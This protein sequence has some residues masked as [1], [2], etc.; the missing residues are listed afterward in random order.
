M[1]T[2]DAPQNPERI[3]VFTD[4]P[5]LRQGDPSLI[6]ECNLLRMKILG[7]PQNLTRL[8]KV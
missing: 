4:R 1:T 5:I 2:T 3:S 7:A 8:F 6:H